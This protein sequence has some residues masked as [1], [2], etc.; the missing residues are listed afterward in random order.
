MM[1]LSPGPRSRRDA[2]ALRFLALCVGGWIALRTMM[3]WNPAWLLSDPG[4]DRWRPPAPFVAPQWRDTALATPHRSDV[5]PMPAPPRRAAAVPVAEPRFA[6]VAEPAPMVGQP[7]AV[8]GRGGG[9]PGFAG[10]GT[11]RHAIRLALIARTLPAPV[12]G[13]ARSALRG[14]LPWPSGAAARHADPGRGA[15]FWMQ[16]DLSGLSFGGWVYL[17]EASSAVPGG[18]AAAGGLGGSQAGARL[19]YGLG[20]TGRTRIYGRAIVALERT[21]QRELAFGVVHAPVTGWPIDL[22]VEQRVA[23]GREGRTALAAFVSGGIGDVPLAKG[24]RL[25]AYGQA[26]VV[27]AQRRDAFADG[28]VAIDRGFGADGAGRLRIGALAAAAVQPGAGRVDVGPRLTLRLPRVGEGSRLALDWRQ[29]IAGEA[30][31]ESGL[32]LT[33]ATDF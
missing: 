13:E 31:P 33:L 7:T 1:M 32:A 28:A 4:A 3:L 22:A 27:G 17:R 30:R 26:G 6:S 29:R 24:F 8:S 25:E 2:S 19:A 15:P 16:R 11:N 10:W 20:A 23:I 5:T 21:R 18:I 14:S 12:G 9:E